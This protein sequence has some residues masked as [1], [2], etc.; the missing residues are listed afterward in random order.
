MAR[1]LQNLY[2]DINNIDL[3]VGGLAEDHVY[4]SELGETFHKIMLE[5]FIRIRDGDR[6]WYKNIMSEEVKAVITFRKLFSLQVITYISWRKTY[7]K[8]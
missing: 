4:D 5:Q 8:I 2:K 6:F 1:K 7:E 3:W